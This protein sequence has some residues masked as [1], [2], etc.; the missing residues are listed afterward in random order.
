MSEDKDKSVIIVQ[1]VT[2]NRYERMKRIII[3]PPLTVFMTTEEIRKE[4]I[5]NYNQFLLQHNK[6]D[7]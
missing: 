3:L 2:A 7:K 5:E 1:A 6:A 4:G